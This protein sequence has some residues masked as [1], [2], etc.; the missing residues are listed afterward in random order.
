M[1][2]RLEKL[3]EYYESALDREYINQ[4]V[5]RQKKASRF[6]K[7]DKP[8]VNVWFPHPEIAGY[9][10]NEI[11]EDMEKMM[12]NELLGVLTHIET[13]GSGV[14]MIRANY[15]VGI[16][17][18]LF[19]ANCRIVNGNMPWVDS[20]GIDGVKKLVKKGIPDH[21]NGLGQK[22]FDTYAFYADVLSKYPKCKELI[23]LYQPDFQGPFD[24]AHLLWGADIYMDIYDEPELVHEFMDL[25][26]ETYIDSM[27]KLKPMLNDEIDGFIC[28]WQH[29]FPGHILLRND[30]AVNLSPTMYEEFV[31]PYD[32]KVLKA[33]GGGSMH[34]CGR[35][36][37]WVF[38]M[39]ESEN[40]YGYNFGYMSNLEFGQKYLNFLKPSYYDKKRAVVAYMLE[41][42]ELATFD[43][44]KYGTGITYN[45]RAKNKEDA[46]EILSL[47]QRNTL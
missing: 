47:C 4:K 46:E 5:E 34:F 29:L 45:V 24:A 10:M 20:V 7:L 43:F 19:G 42:E 1:L 36:D 25:I 6:E 13:D 15:G 30:S 18:S 44:N 37:Q 31:K 33:F 38:K 16:L 2:D 17:P 28:Q 14:P 21:R 8:C 3:L 35:A 23:H 9:T 27:K 39:A 40:I 11:H 41:K 26:S 12:F 22:V 32:E